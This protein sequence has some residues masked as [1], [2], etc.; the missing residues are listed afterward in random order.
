M[1]EGIFK[2][3]MEM[4]NNTIDMKGDFIMQDTCYN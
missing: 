2:K 3:G 1:Q 4:N